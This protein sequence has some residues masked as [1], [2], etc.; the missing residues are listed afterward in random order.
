MTGSILSKKGWIVIPKE[1]RQK[2]CLKKGERVN[3]VDYGGV[4]SIIPLARDAISESEGFLSGGSPLTES[5]VNERRK[6]RERGK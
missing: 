5:L 4:I 3:I 2:Y 6:D 1:I